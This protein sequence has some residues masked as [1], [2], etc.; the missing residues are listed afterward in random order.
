MWIYN[1]N[2][3]NA[4]AGTAWAYDT[5]LLSKQWTRVIWSVDN[6][7]NVCT[8]SEKRVPET[9][10]IGAQL[11]VMGFPNN[12]DGKP[13]PRGTFYFSPMMGRYGEENSIVELGYE[14]GAS[15]V[16]VHENTAYTGEFV[17]KDVEGAKVHG[18]D[19]GSYKITMSSKPAHN[20]EIY[21]RLTAPLLSD[22]QSYDYLTLYVYNANNYDAKIGTL[23]T[24]D[25]TLAANSWN[26]VKYPVS[27]FTEKNVFD[28]ANEKPGQM[29]R[30]WNI[31][32]FSIRIH[33]FGNNTTGTFYLSS[34]L[35]EMAM[36]K[37]DEIVSFNSEADKDKLAVCMVNQY[38]GS[39]TTEQ[40][41]GS[42]AGSYKVTV[43]YQNDATKLQDDHIYVAI[44][45]PQIKNVRAY[46]YLSVNI[47]NPNNFDAKAGILWGADTV[48]KAGEWTELRIL[49]PDHHNA[50]SWVPNADPDVFKTTRTWMADITNLII[51]IFG[52]EGNKHAE[53]GTTFYFSGIRAVADSKVDET[54]LYAFDEAAPESGTDGFISLKDGVT[55]ITVANATDK[56]FGKETSSTKITYNRASA[57]ISGDLLFGKPLQDA[58]F[59]YIEF[60]VYNE[61]NQ[62]F[63]VGY[64][65]GG[66][67]LCKKGEWTT[68]KW[69]LD[70]GR[71]IKGATR[72]PLEGLKFRIVASDWKTAFEAGSSIYVSA[73]YGYN[74]IG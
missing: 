18:D 48:L 7:G 64:E 63:Y 43:D 47:Y 9:N 58:C 16:T 68:V 22:V 2:D 45:K 23:W 46:N 24:A 27:M 54:K 17:S 57:D 50:E 51:R 73:L 4:S 60:S 38:T 44:A 36:M 11:R 32:G 66:D 35:G 28:V 14:S 53:E 10:I 71:L 74:V 12:E 39:Y 26:R 8:T 61:T 70:G 15:R 21:L 69:E 42:E 29:L 62:D 56:V 1:D 33:G 49:Y 37:N 65:W 67:T 19:A 20:G 34:I 25:Q 55:D 31:T 41:Y 72:T 13:Y 3:F 5:V 52:A 30:P 59:D 6:W 40:H